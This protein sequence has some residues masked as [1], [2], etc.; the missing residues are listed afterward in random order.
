MSQEEKR[1][2]PS[3]RTFLVSLIGLLLSV[4]AWAAAPTYI[5]PGYFGPNAFPV[6][7]MLDGRA[8]G[9][10]HAEIAADGYF[11][12]SGD[13]TADIF[14]KLNIPLFT[15]RVNLSVW[16]PIY[17]WYR[18]EHNGSGAGDVYVSTDIWLF[19]ERKYV[20]DVAFRAALKTASG[21]Q[22]A[23]KRHFDGPGYWFDLSAGKSFWVQDKVEFRLAGTI[24][25]LCWQTTTARQNDALYY[26]LQG[27]VN[28][29]YLSMSAT[30]SGYTGWE[31]AG[32]RPMVIAARLTGHVRNFNP[33]IQYQYGIKDYPYHQIRVGISY[34]WQYVAPSKKKAFKSALLQ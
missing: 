15:D 25:F 34:E 27:Q 4:Q 9:S 17:E 6:P 13:Q 26:G 31:Q 28:S 21:G 23:Q 24:G 10:L 5:S 33:F 16:M 12:Q 11:G 19:K 2:S 14:F 8:N 29:R 7:A 18:G 20:P 30:W 22:F 1:R 3:S 32:D